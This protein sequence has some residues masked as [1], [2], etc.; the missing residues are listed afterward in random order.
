MK[1]KWSELNIGALLPLAAVLVL[2]VIT[3]GVRDAFILCKDGNCS[4]SIPANLSEVLKFNPK[5]D[6]ALPSDPVEASKEMLARDTR[7]R[8]N[9]ALKYGGRVT[10][11]FLAIANLFVYVASLAIVSIVLFRLFPA[12]RSA[13]ILLLICGLSIVV[14]YDFYAHPEKHMALFLPL[15][16][17]TIV[18]DVPRITHI[19]NLLNSAGNGVALALILTTCAILW[20]RYAKSAPNGLNDLSTAMKSLRLIL[21]VGTLLLVAAVLLKKSLY[22]WS[23]AFTSRDEQLAKAA[24]GFLSSFLSVEGGFYTLML[25]AMYLPAAYLIHRRA[26]RL[27]NLP[28]EEAKVEEALKTHGLAFSFTESL[29]RILA[30]LGP[31]IAGP[32]GDLLKGAY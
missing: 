13:L 2:V 32:V 30:I 29:P 22:Q 15:F 14:G 5:D 4:E 24:E 25:A 1:I 21:Y 10:W 26:L 12:R 8:K 20:C 11:S 3:T 9:R 27:G 23:L 18:N 28:K 19:T 6:P 31:V 7:D 17:Q 16:E